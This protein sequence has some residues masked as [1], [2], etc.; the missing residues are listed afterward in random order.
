LH[1][2]CVLVETAV[3]AKSTL[4]IES[5]VDQPKDDV[6]VCVARRLKNLHRQS[7][8]MAVN[9]TSFLSESLLD[10]VFQLLFVIINFKW[11]ISFHFVVYTVV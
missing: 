9:E 1:A 6:V 7:N 4:V 2:V 10:G 8:A 11:S 5:E 3:I